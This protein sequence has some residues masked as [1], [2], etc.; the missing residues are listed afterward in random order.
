MIMRGVIFLILISVLN[1][2]V[3]G[4]ELPKIK[5][6]S[7]LPTS[8]P[9]LPKFDLP[10]LP[11]MDSLTK[12]SIRPKSESPRQKTVNSYSEDI[13]FDTCFGEVCTPWSIGLDVSYEF[14]NSNSYV[15]IIV[16]FLG[17]NLLA[18]KLS[19]VSLS[20]GHLKTA[21]SPIF[22]EIIAADSKKKFCISLPVP[23]VSP[24]ACISLSNLLL[25]SNEGL[26]LDLS[27]TLDALLYEKDLYFKRLKFY[28][29]AAENTDKTT[30][31][32][33]QRESLEECSLNPNCGWCTHNSGQ[34][35][36]IS[37]NQEE[38]TDALGLCSR[39]GF[40]KGVKSSEE[41]YDICLGRVNCGKCHKD[42]V[43]GNKLDMIGWKSCSKGWDYE[44]KPADTLLLGGGC[45][46]SGEL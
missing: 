2:G 34:C 29:Q 25:G 38:I 45:G 14:L 12:F 21:S 18:K 22:G 15:Q 23:V 35:L 32:C 8:L 37:N 31:S 20:D 27:V 30:T 40:F 28:N 1:L 17:K 7:L 42:C 36:P 4:W 11:E 41:L 3:Y 39:C 16:K 33:I 13:G 9:D 24:R 10:D 44:R 19:I 6:P 46:V 5:I 26:L 43:E